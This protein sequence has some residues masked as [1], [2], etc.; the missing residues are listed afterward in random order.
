MAKDSGRR[1]RGVAA[2]V[3]IKLEAA[4]T[5]RQLY[6]GAAAKATVVGYLEDRGFTLAKT[7]L[8][9]H[10]QEENLTFLRR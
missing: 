7:E 8:Q 1:I 5:T 10:D 4:V 2:A 3:E 9:S 6:C